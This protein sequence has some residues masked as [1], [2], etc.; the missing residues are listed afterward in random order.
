[1]RQPSSCEVPVLPRLV[2]VS[3]EIVALDERLYPLLEVHRR[4]GKLELREK[5]AHEQGV[6]QGL[7]C[8]HDA[9]DGRVHLHSVK[10]MGGRVRF[11]ELELGM[12]R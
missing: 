11:L 6:R 10:S 8:L 5:L 9:H 1:M 7:S 4:G 12:F 2:G 3:L